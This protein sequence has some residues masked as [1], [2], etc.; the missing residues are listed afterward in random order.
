MTNKDEWQGLVVGGMLMGGPAVYVIRAFSRLNSEVRAN[1]AESVGVVLLAVL[2]LAYVNHK[3]NRIMWPTDS[4]QQL[5]E[6]GDSG[7]D[8]GGDGGGA[9]SNG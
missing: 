2:F 4:Q 8:E 9:T 3:N 5:G 6:P 1:I 7:A